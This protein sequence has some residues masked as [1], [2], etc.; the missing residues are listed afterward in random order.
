[1]GGN[2]YNRYNNKNQNGGKGS[3][4][5]KFNYLNPPNEH[6][7]TTTAIPDYVTDKECMVN[8]VMKIKSYINILDQRLK[9]K[10]EIDS[11]LQNWW[12]FM[13]EKYDVKDKHFFVIQKLGVCEHI[14]YQYVLSDQLSN[15]NGNNDC[16]YFCEN[17]LCEVEKCLTFMK[18]RYRVV[19]TVRTNLYQIENFAGVKKLLHVDDFCHD[20]YP[21]KHSAKIEDING[22]VCNIAYCTKG[23]IR[24]LMEKQGITHKLM[25]NHFIKEQDDDSSSVFSDCSESDPFDADINESIVSSYHLVEISKVSGHVESVLLW[26]ENEDNFKLE[27]QKYL[28]TLLPEKDRQHI[29]E[30][31][32][33][34]INVT[35][36]YGAGC[37]IL[38]DPI[39]ELGYIL[40]KSYEI[41]IRNKKLTSNTIVC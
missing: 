17:E 35:V 11:R 7:V 29:E 25:V 8:V 6:P 21:C 28:L 34:M 23:E 12:M 13:R 24:L 20:F 32:K 14:K 5:G 22:N 30:E 1:M 37:G 2:K 16:V 18:M 39:D 31:L 40:P 15:F 9:K 19:K 10:K 36:S 33:Q 27:C 3:F 38:L 4:F 26:S 41:R